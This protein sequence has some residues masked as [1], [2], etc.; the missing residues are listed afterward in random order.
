M[1]SVFDYVRPEHGDLVVGP[2]G[3]FAGRR[4]GERIPEAWTWRSRAVAVMLERH[5]LAFLPHRAAAADR[6]MARV[7]VDELLS[8]CPVRELRRL[9]GGLEWARAELAERAT[10]HTIGHL[11]ERGAKDELQAAL[12]AAHGLAEPPAPDPEP[13][14]QD[15]APA[16]P[17]GPPRDLA[18]ELDRSTDEE[19]LAEAEAA[20]VAP[21]GL[22]RDE[23][24]GAI[25]SAHGWT[26]LGPDA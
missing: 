10:G 26:E 8:A 12:L 1:A 11:A 6:T 19:L 7:L 17:S 5:Q 23:L 22:T 25:L 13:V 24:I 14:P 20:G 9:V 21:E 2:R 3:R 15:E 4:V 16:K 18:A